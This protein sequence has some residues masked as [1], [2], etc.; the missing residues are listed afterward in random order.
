M[1]EPERL[2]RAPQCRPTFGDPY[3][4]HLR[5]RRSDDPAVPALHLFKEI[6]AI[7][8]QGSFNLLYRYITQGRVEADRRPISPRRLARLLL[9]RPDSLK[10]E[11]RHLLDDLTTA[12]PQMIDLA[13][14][15]RAFADL[16]RPHEDNA[17]R[18]NAWITTARTCDLPHLHA[19]ARGLDQDR[20]AVR[21][22]HV[23]LPQR[24]HR[25]RRHEDQAHH[26]P[27]A[28]PGR[29]RVAPPPHSPGLT[30]RHH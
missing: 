2:Q 8:Y 18:L 27:D 23:V 11:H 25:R 6:K 7:G 29:L 20:D 17:E 19:F 21:G 14:P 9:T 3:R 26:A 24:Q 4:D 10:D 13:G 16:L 22:R 15:M 30:L 1:G 12:C 28:Q 5:R